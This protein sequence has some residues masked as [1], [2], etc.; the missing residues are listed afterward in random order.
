MPTGTEF[1]TWEGAPCGYEGVLQGQFRVM[2]AIAQHR[3]LAPRSEPE[4]WPA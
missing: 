2:L 3:G 4:W 1:F